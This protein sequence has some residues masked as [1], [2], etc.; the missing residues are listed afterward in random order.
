MKE[1]QQMVGDW[2]L[3]RPTML[4]NN[5]FHSVVDL[6]RGEVDELV[7]AH[8]NGDNKD[9]AQEVAD[10][11]IFALTLANIL[12]VDVDAEVKEKMAYNLAR[13][14]A[15]KFQSGSYQQS[16]EECRAWVKET[17]WKKEFYSIPEETQVSSPV[18]SQKMS[19]Q[20]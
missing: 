7:E 8:P 5:T 17:G 16:R 6:L 20:D 19:S 3:D 9:I 4:E 10:V 15:S 1:L 11:F 2:L 12:G 14:P 18:S 13:Y